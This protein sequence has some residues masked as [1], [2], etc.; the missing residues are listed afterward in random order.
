MAEAA[1]ALETID[2][3]YRAAVEPELWP[4]ALQSLALSTGGIGT[5][6]IPITPQN[7]AGLI[8]SPE[9][10]E[11]NIEYEREWWRH[12]TRV[13]R[14]HTRKL[15]GGVCCEAELF[16]GDEL[17]R[18]PLRQEFLR[19]YGIGSFAAQLVAPVP[20]FVVALSVCSIS[21]M[22]RSIL[23]AAAALISC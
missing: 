9:L 6:M 7:T 5:A 22:N 20:D 3:L 12:D 14:I 19:S 18:D 11:P 17:A 13:L 23:K 15:K 21:C 16:T 10:Q 1:E 8:V 4:E 2:L